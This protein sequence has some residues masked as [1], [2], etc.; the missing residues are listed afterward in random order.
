[1]TRSFEGYLLSFFLLLAWVVSPSLAMDLRLDQDAW[2]FG[3]GGATAAVGGGTHSFFINPA[4]TDRAT[5]PMAQLDGV[6]RSNGFPHGAHLVVLFPTDDATVFGLGVAQDSKTGAYRNRLLQVSAARPLI[7][8]RYLTGGVALKLLESSLDDEPVQKAHGFSM[9][10]GLT[11]DKPLRNGDTLSFGL[12]VRDA[13]GTLRFNDHHEDTLTR[14]FTLAA[15]YQRN[16]LMRFETDFDLVDRGDSR[17]DMKSRMRLGVERFCVRRHI[18]VRAGF[19]DVFSS[20]GSLTAGAGYHPDRPYEIQAGLGLSE[21]DQSLS[22]S[23][24]VVYRLDGWKGRDRVG[25]KVADID[26][27]AGE[28]GEP[29]LRNEGRPVSPVPVRRMEFSVDP[30]VISPDGDGQNDA[31]TLKITGLQEDYYSRWEWVL[32]H[33]GETG[34]FRAFSGNG[35]P[36]NTLVWDGMDEEGHPAPDGRYEIILRVYNR[37][38]YVAAQDIQHIEVRTGVLHLALHAVTK[39]FSPG[40]LLAKNRVSFQVTT[41]AGNR[42][43]RWEFSVNDAQTQSLVYVMRGVGHPPRSIV[44]RGLDTRGTTAPEAVYLCSLSAQD[45]G[46]KVLKSDPVT[47]AVDMTPPLVSFETQQQ[48]VDLPGGTADFR[49][50]AE[51]ANGIAAWK[52][53]ILDESGNPYRT[54]KGIGVPPVRWAWDGMGDRGGESAKPGDYF[55]LYLEATD[56][57]GNEAKSKAIALQA[58]PVSSASGQT[59]MSLNLTTVFF[60]AD[61]AVLDEESVRNLRGAIESIRPYIDKSSLVVKGCAAPGE[62]GDL[63]KLSH[64]R[65]AAVRDFLAQGL[66]IDPSRIQTAGMGTQEP[67]MVS[68]GAAPPDRQRRV[69]VALTTTP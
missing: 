13:S 69:W 23:F 6:W 64:E 43:A 49:L 68:G 15:A 12:V 14:V 58:K 21:K 10:L 27:A 24:S 25:E 60:E 35:T 1:M 18:S 3:M 36:P 65:A 4:G 57:A 32:N 5:V 63:T 55:T 56:A 7:T 40:S 46:G 42:L 9:D 19:D 59:Q 37:E 2:S 31:A 54:E 44:W 28:E 45:K 34:A 52:L 30:P 33:E 29:G 17:S 11:Y 47:V 22:G 20:T 41:D 62:T 38:S 67:L 51:D 8:S 48:L 39:A 26:L 53:V 66:K 50:G 61:S 16:P